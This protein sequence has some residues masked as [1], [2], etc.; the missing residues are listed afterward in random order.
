MPDLSDL[1]AFGPVPS[2]RFGRSL[3]VN[4]VPHKMCTYSC[5]YCQLGRTAFTQ[6]RRRVYYESMDI[7]MAVKKQLLEVESRG[8]TVDFITFVPD[9][10]PTLD[11]NL[12]DEIRRIKSYGQKIAVITNGSLLWHKDVRDD[13]QLADWVSI[14][15]DSIRPLTWRNLN[16]ADQSLDLEKILDGMLD[17]SSTYSG[18]LSTET[19]LINDYN[20]SPEEL[21]STAGFIAQ[22]HPD[23][24]YVAIPTRPP[25]EK[26]VK[27]ATP[28]KLAVSYFIFSGHSLNTEYLIGYEGNAFAS[29]GNPKT[30][31]LSITSVHPMRKEAVIKYLEETNCEWQTV[32]ALLAAGELLEINYNESTFYVRNFHKRVRFN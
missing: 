17:F 14:K 16:G 28:Y 31:L 11:Q 30:D 9:G 5:V 6:N 15:V 1:L 22:V 7:S 29:T 27:A 21:D 32:K 12:G 3:G 20:D 19:M 4:N 23:K 25:A 13:L 2:R 8:E 18:V 26:W 10:E 24:C